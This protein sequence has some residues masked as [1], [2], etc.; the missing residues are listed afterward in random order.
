MSAQSSKKLVVV[1][2]IALRAVIAGICE[3]HNGGSS[4]FIAASITTAVESLLVDVVLPQAKACEKPSNFLDPMWDHT[5]EQLLC[6]LEKPGCR[7]DL[8]S[9]FTFMAEHIDSARKAIADLVHPEFELVMEEVGQ[10]VEAHGKPKK[11][12]RAFAEFRKSWNQLR[13]SHN[14][15]V[16]TDIEAID[17]KWDAMFSRIGAYLEAKKSMK[18]DMAEFS[19]FVKALHRHRLALLPDY[20]QRQFSKRSDAV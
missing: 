4:A 5:F 14:I 17:E 2:V 9:P 19:H 7:E 3:S 10:E 18:H 12:Q 11:H 20:Y 8:I 16:L 1:D 13:A 6:L 15:S